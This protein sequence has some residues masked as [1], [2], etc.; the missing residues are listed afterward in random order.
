MIAEF[1]EKIELRGTGLDDEPF[2]H[3]IPI[4]LN[5]IFAQDI[6]G[7]AATVGHFQAGGILWTL[8][9]VLA[10][11]LTHLKRRQRRA[12]ARRSLRV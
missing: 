1:L 2:E 3:E 6:L 12:R 10:E 8:G 11:Q 5:G 4:K 9:K 7:G